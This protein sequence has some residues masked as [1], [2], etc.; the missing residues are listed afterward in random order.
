MSHIKDTLVVIM[1]ARRSKFEI[2]VDVLIEIKNGSQ[3]PTKIM[4]GAN[5]SWK[6]L[7]QILKSLVQQNLII[8][9]EGTRKDK[10]TKSRYQLTNK[11]ENVVRYFI[12]ARNLVELS[13]K[14]VD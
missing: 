14:D 10:R 9:F 3:K 6:P 1:S 7:Q 2:Y 8:E 11:G 5:L 12:K 13:P 4:Y